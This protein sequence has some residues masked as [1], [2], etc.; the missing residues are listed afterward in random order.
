MKSPQSWRGRTSR[1]DLMADD[2][3]TMRETLL[4]L[5]FIGMLAAVILVGV[6]CFA[7]GTLQ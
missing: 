2:P 6:T 1:D 5:G 7:V 3:F 4:I